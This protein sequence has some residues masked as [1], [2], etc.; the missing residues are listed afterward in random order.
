[1]NRIYVHHPRGW[2]LATV[3]GR[4]QGRERLLA[5]LESEQEARVQ[6]LTETE[7]E[8]LR[9]VVDRLIP[10][11]QDPSGW[12]AGVGEYL[13]RQLQGDL[14][15]QISLYRDGL[16]ALEAE[17]RLAHGGLAF[18][19]LPP[20]AQD[21]LLERVEAGS[22]RA[23]WTVSPA[24]FFQQLLQHTVEGYYSDPANGGNRDGVAWRMVGF[25]VKA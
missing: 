8:T 18:A 1:M 10:A 23:A 3:R 11:D 19:A 21:A 17:A 2:N 6:P 16:T 7:R 24:L 5:N 15:Q 4:A 12:E 9:A 14:A 22:V 25:E 13:S 20:E